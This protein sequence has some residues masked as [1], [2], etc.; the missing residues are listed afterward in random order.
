MLNSGVSK[1]GSSIGA[2]ASQQ[3]GEFG[4]SGLNISNGYLYEEFLPQLQGERGRRALREMSD[5]DDTV[6]ATL[7]AID[8]LLKAVPW[9][10]EANEKD[11]TGEYAEF[12]ESVIDDME[13]T[14]AELISEIL[15]M[16]IFGWAY[17]ETVF[18]RRIGPYEKDP[19]RRSRY[20]D[21]KI[22]IRKIAPRAQESIDRWEMGPN[23]DILGMWQQG[24]G[25]DSGGYFIPYDHALL[26]RT[27]SRKNNP[28]GRSILRTAYM[29][30][31]NKKKIQFYEATGIE[32]DLTGLPVLKVP[33]E[34]LMDN[35]SPASKAMLSRLIKIS[36]DLKFNEQA[37]VILPSDPW[38]DEDGKFTST[39]RVSLE[40]MSASGGRT[41]DTNAVVGRYSTSI[42]RVILADWL[43][44][45]SSSGSGSYALS[46]NKTQIF[47]QSTQGYI[48]NIA[49]VFNRVMLPR[50]WKLNGWDTQFMPKL[51]P[52]TVA[53]EDLEKFGKYIDTLANAGFTLAGDPE[54]EKLVRQKGGLPEEV[55]PEILPRSL[56]MQQ[57]EFEAQQAQQA[58]N[59]AKF[60]EDAK[61]QAQQAKVKPSAGK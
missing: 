19:S 39:P 53:P 22:G 24:A 8:T 12:V 3:N 54:T 15:T 41:I 38:R 26:F 18:K 52:G 57:Q 25:D 36:R 56:Q 34:I 21:G 16:L 47:F 55:D 5:N 1:A 10:V 49:Q 35:A 40:L 17:F 9:N 59:D 7:Y 60:A 29:P 14:W 33:S 20:T 32:R 28:E 6:G 4:V 51:N 43:M 42:A 23:G 13:C 2:S 46:D 37:S 44:L 50:L 48:E 27:T 45:G 61:R 31:F 30:Y 11:T 58:A